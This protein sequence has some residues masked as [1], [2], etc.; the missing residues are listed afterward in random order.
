MSFIEGQDLRQ[1]WIKSAATDEKRVLNLIH[2]LKRSKTGLILLS[3]AAKKAAQHG[4]T[5]TD[6][7]IPGEVSITDTTLI[8]RFDRDNPLEMIYETKS[9]IFINIDLSFQDAILDLAHE[10][11][12]FNYKEPFNPYQPGFSATD[13]LKSTLDGKGGEVEA[14]LVECK[15]MAEIFPSAVKKLS[16]CHRIQ[17]DEKKIFSKAMATKL[18]YQLG[19]FHKM[20]EEEVGQ[21]GLKASDI[22]P[23]SDGEALF[24][25][26]A[27]GLPYPLASLREYQG[28]MTKVC[29]NDQKRLGL[30]RDSIGR[31]LASVQKSGNQK[32]YEKINAN[33]QSRCPAFIK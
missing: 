18:F 23:Y 16:H 11:T 29:Q 26:S 22:S 7:I 30:L 10:L 21:L 24:I 19:D 15:V 12:H 25:S 8:R 27:Y 9:K 33:F 28:I 17:D 2:Y 6:V 4:E 32:L 5:L 3:Q 1:K 13:F 14:Y 20:F 31:T